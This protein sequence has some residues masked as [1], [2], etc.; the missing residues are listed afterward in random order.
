MSYGASEDK[1]LGIPGENG[2]NVLSAK[3]FVGWYNGHPWD[4]NLQ[5]SL[6][7]VDTVVIIGNGNVAVDV[8]RILLKPVEEL[9]GTDICQHAIDVLK[10][11]DVRN[12]HIV[13][14][15]GPLQS[16]FTAK[17]LRELCSLKRVNVNIDRTFLNEQLVKYSNYL[18]GNRRYKRM[19]EIL[20]SSQKLPPHPLNKNLYFDFLSSPSE[21]LLDEDRCVKGVEL[22]ENE[23]IE[24]SPETETNVHDQR[25]RATERKKALSCQ[26]LVRSIGYQG[27]VFPGI[28]FDLKRSLVPNDRGRV[29]LDSGEVC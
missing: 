21:I 9:A 24:D 3:S 15:R 14:R 11:S 12:V 25:V 26:L 17:E 16:A 2:V 27:V 1:K 19:T 5:F 23:L 13:G 28:P 4:K 18:A 7:D 8:A 29:I 10:S 22:I 6:K 20:S